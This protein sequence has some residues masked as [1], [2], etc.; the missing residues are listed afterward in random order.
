MAMKKEEIAAKAR[1]T[2]VSDLLG[3]IMVGPPDEF[4]FKQAAGQELFELAIKK[5]E[6]HDMTTAVALR[7]YASIF[8]RLDLLD[9][10]MSTNGLSSIERAAAIAK[11]LDDPPSYS[12]EDLRND[13][14]RYRRVTGKQTC[15]RRTLRRQYELLRDYARK[16]SYPS[17]TLAARGQRSTWVRK[18]LLAMI[19]LAAEVPCWHPRRELV[20]REWEEFMRDVDKKTSLTQMIALVLAYIHSTTSAYLLNRLLPRRSQ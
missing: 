10:K 1:R 12:L 2:A 7:R 17:K 4:P 18:H 13:F 20:A 3:V 15:H 6:V 8:G 16:N 11:W 9:L 5:L 14:D 19:A